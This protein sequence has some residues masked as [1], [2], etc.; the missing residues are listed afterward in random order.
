M[1]WRDGPS[2]RGRPLRFRTPLVTRPEPHPTIG[3]ATDPTR[4]SGSGRP[5]QIAQAATV[6]AGLAV[7]AVVVA[8]PGAARSIVA[9]D[10]RVALEVLSLCAVTFAAVILS[11]PEDRD[12]RPARNA[13][14]SG[15]AVLA[16]SNAVF[17]VTPALL[18]FRIPLDHGL[19]YYPWLAARYVAG[20]L[21]IASGLERPRLRLAT[22]VLAGL[23]L[24]AAID[25]ALLVVPG[26]LPVPV[27]IVGS[28]ETATVVVVSPVINVL[29]QTVPAVLF[30]V[31]AALAGRLH[32]RSGAPAYRWLSLSL[33]VQLFAQV[34]EV[35]APAFLG[36]VISSADGVRLVAVLLLVVAAVHQLAYLYRD[37]TATVRAQQRDLRSR[38]DLLE[39]LRVFAER[40][41]DFRSLVSHELATPVATIRAF[42]HVLEAETGPSRSERLQLAVAGIEAESRR[43]QELINRMDEL[44]ELELKAFSCELRPIMLRP[45]LE[46][47]AMF[48]RGLPGVHPVVLR[49]TD[50]RVLADPL[51]L[52]QAL[53]NIVVNA[54]R[55]TPPHSPVA[56]EATHL[57]Q[58]VRVSITDRG[59]GIPPDER[60]RVKRRYARGS[61][62][63]GTEGQGLGLYLAD[64]VVNAHGGRLSL[65]DADGGGT[66]VSFELEVST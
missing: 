29:L 59:P 34:H 42:T 45:V 22:S 47:A 27:R 61:G 23:A 49:T 33:L 39:E 55:Y 40:E 35:L 24:L 32:L 6:V 37:R 46:D 25:V 57:E 30:G 17:T 60:R 38:E 51:R 19:A 31:G 7:T 26:D 1:R 5:L 15:L 63:R 2:P 56:I 52:S 12:V 28:G 20:L 58:R 9:P 10:L 65:T 13:L 8:V 41:H 50:A 36:P 11:L 4:V 48:V 3:D 53:R 18:G 44:R 43:L 64:R 54:V 62:S 16:L 66:A 21:F 14:V